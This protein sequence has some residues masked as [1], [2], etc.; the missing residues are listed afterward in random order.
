MWSARWPHGSRRRCAAPHHEGL[1]ECGAE[2][3]R[4]RARFPS[5]T[6]TLSVYAY[7]TTMRY[8]DFSYGSTIAVALVI[9][10]ALVALVLR[11]LL[12]E[13]TA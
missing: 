3:P 2:L 6:E 4:S 5:A 1:T 10:L 12:R 13:V 11:R 9:L 8:L 7:Q